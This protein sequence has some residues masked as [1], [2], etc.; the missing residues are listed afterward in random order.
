[1]AFNRPRFADSTD[2]QTRHKLIC[3][4]KIKY[5]TRAEAYDARDA[6]ISKHNYHNDPRVG[7]VDIYQCSVCKGWHLGHDRRRTKMVIAEHVSS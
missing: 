6:L 4:S 5:D 7:H 2:R 1:M 3:A